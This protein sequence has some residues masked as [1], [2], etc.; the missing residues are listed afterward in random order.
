MDY[1]K[2]Y[3]NLNGRFSISI[4]DEVRYLFKEEDQHKAAFALQITNLL[5]R[6]IFCSRLGMYDVPLSIAFFSS[7]D[8]D[9]VIRKEVNLDCCTLS[10]PHG[11]RIGYNIPFG[12][13]LTMDD[14]LNKQ[15]VAEISRFDPPN[16]D[17]NFA[18]EEFLHDHLIED[19]NDLDSFEL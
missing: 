4:H 5:T 2:K 19:E 11:L 18:K 12:E 6:S 14:I 15:E 10:N 3:Y 7:V 17:K 16:D 1:L 13:S 8:I 9:R